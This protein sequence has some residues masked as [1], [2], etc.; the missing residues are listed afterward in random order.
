MKEN[1]L[2]FP[3]CLQTAC[4][5]WQ[6][7]YAALE[8]LP[9]PGLSLVNP[10]SRFSTVYIRLP[11]SLHEAQDRIPSA[12]GS[13]AGTHPGFLSKIN[14]NWLL[15]TCF[16]TIQERL[17][18]KSTCSHHGLLVVWMHFNWHKFIVTAVKASIVTSIHNK[19]PSV[20]FKVYSSKAADK[21][22][23]T[24]RSI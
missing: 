9:V 11:G 23:L 21:W 15:S 13:S 16:F 22:N 6:C 3:V 5:C 18:H 8:L 10:P 12:A 7:S 24:A 4:G 2:K 1:L 14:R 17:K 19:Y 20:T